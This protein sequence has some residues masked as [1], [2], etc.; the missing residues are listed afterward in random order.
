MIEEQATV[1]DCEGEYAWVETQRQSSCGQCSVRGGCGTQVLSK[2]LGKKTAYVR[3]LNSHHVKIGDKVTIGIEESALL[4]GS[5]LLYLLPLL[6]MLVF[7]GLSSFISGLWWPEWADLLA[8]AASFLGLVLG[9]SFSNI[10][11]QRKSVQKKNNQT[12]Y[13]PVILKKLPQTEWELKRLV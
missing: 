4:S 8:V 13:E 9:L 10:Y 6:V 2:V 11:V 7:G 1:V 5:F 3:C 12:R